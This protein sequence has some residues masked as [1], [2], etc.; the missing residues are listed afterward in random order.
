MSQCTR[1]V[2]LDVHARKIVVAYADA[3][4]SEPKLRGQIPNEP[5]AIEALMER[6]GPAGSL[7]VCYEAGPCGYVIYRQ[8]RKLGIHCDVIAPSMMPKRPGDRVKTDNRDALNLARSYRNG[9]LIAV[10]VPDEQTEALRELRRGRDVAK[11][12]ERRGRQ[13]LRQLL[14]RCGIHPPPKVNPWTQRYMKWLDDLRLPHASTQRTLRDLMSEVEHQCARVAALEAEL[15]EAMKTA[16]QELREVVA[17]LQAMRGIAWLSA[18]TLTLE[19]G[20]FA[21][22][23]SPRELMAW[24]GLVPSEY[25]SGEAQRRG[26]ITKAG[27][28]HVRRTCVESAWNQARAPR[29]SAELQRRRKGLPPSVIDIA[30]R[31]QERLHT[32][33]KRL[34]ARGKTAKR[35]VVAVARELLGFVWAIAREVEHRRAT[36]QSLPEATAATKLVR[37]RA[38]RYRLKA[39]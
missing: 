2:G 9:D 7:R 24:A 4:G 35:V 1:W 10:W 27:N 30:D 26:G 29:P 21:R 8:L 12:C 22:F 13:Q 36:G 6:L 38:R 20:C 18:L 3:D 11:E 14:L 32:R 16:P 15:E 23:K 28:A 25:S 5:A 17:A 31:A 34:A 37:P 19:V 39:A 33:F